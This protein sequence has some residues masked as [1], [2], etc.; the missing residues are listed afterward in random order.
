MTPAELQAA[1]QAARTECVAKAQLTLAT[2]DAL[3]DAERDCEP[4]PEQC[5]GTRA[6]CTCHEEEDAW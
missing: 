3:E 1:G 6:T 2:R 4:C 5:G